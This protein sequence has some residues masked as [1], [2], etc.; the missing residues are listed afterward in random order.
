MLHLNV[1]KTNLLVNLSQFFPLLSHPCSV[2]IS[3]FNY[4]YFSCL[5]YWKSAYFLLY[6]LESISLKFQ[7]EETFHSTTTYLSI[8]VIPEF[9][10]LQIVATAS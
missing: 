1:K 3:P 10:F 9:S 4:I 5:T 6:F 8:I 2:H 7:F